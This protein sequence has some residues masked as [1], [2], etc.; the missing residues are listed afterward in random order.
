MT[1]PQNAYQQPAY[2]QP[3]VYYAP[4]MVRPPGNGLATGS[5]VTGI[6]GAFFG[7]SVPIPFLGLF[8]AIVAVPL[9]IVAIALGFPGLPRARRVGVGRGASIAGIVLG[10]FALGITI[11]V[12]IGWIILAATG[13]AA[14][15]PSATPM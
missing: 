12:T 7:L 10:F 3:V 9:G 1:D 5:L 2:G 15:T 8:S 13:A 14:P 11:L 4:M 6:I